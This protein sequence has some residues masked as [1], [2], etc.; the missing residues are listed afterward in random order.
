MYR[1]SST[2]EIT[3]PDRVEIFAQIESFLDPMRRQHDF[4]ILMDISNHMSSLSQAL[5]RVSSAQYKVCHQHTERHIQYECLLN[6][7]HPITRDDATQI[8]NWSTS[9]ILCPFSA[10]FTFLSLFVLHRRYFCF[11]LRVYSYSK[12]TLL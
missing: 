3:C 10:I 11:L 9:S 4:L 8:L 1:N 6:I 12:H 5:S 2:E 7:S